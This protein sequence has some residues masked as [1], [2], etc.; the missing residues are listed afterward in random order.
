[1][2]IE[3]PKILINEYLFKFLIELPCDSIDTSYVGVHA[4]ST[5]VSQ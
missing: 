4:S 1:M 2:T 3:K 5:H